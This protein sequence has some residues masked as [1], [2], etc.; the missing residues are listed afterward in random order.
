MTLLE[1]ACELLVKYRDNL[2]LHPNKRIKDIEVYAFLEKV[3]NAD[4]RSPE[5]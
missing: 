3:K 1:E 2:L 5:L 4:S